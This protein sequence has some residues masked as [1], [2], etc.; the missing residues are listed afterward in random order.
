MLQLKTKPVVKL[1]QKLPSNSSPKTKVKTSKKLKE[2]SSSSP[3]PPLTTKPEEKKPQKL[4]PIHLKRSPQP[5]TPKKDKVV[6]KLD[7]VAKRSFVPTY[8][9]HDCD[10]IPDDQDDDI[11]NDGLLDRTQDSDWDGLLNHVDEDDDNDGW[12]IKIDPNYF[13]YPKPIILFQMFF[14]IIKNAILFYF[15]NS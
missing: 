12:F 13:C 9:D 2:S 14:N 11:D 10:G 3:L 4:N 6:P 7:V 5:V 1:P 15:R 8:E